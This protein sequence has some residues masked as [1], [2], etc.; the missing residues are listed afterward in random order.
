M[1]LKDL[2]VGVPGVVE[3]RGDME[4]EI[5][6]LVSDSRETAQKAMF[7]CVSGAKF[8]AHL[9]APQAQENGAVALLYEQFELLK[10]VM[11]SHGSDL[12]V[13]AV[14]WLKYLQLPKEVN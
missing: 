5:E 9:F 12:F 13:P 4:T 14:T 8:D 2:L 11:D 1:K 6:S 7:F 10:E 3:T